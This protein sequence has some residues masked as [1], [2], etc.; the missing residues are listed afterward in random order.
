MYLEELQDE[1]IE[2][3]KRIKNIRILRLLNKILNELEQG[4]GNV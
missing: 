2:R 4:E 3:V 1:L